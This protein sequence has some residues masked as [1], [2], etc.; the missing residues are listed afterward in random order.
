M[1]ADSVETV[2]EN[3]AAA[4]AID[5]N[6][7]SI[8]HTQWQAASPP[9]PHTFTVNLGVARTRGRFQV[10]ATRR[11]W[12][13]HH[14]PVALLHQRGRCELDQVAQGNFADAG[15]NASEKTVQFSTAPPPNRTPSLATISNQ[16]SVT[17]QADLAES[18]R[19][20]PGR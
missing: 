13:W 17:G 15:N 10:P 2:G 20:G 5:G 1:T 8:W 7:A 12:Q 9:P 19:F 16:N 18:Q 14:R 4:N 11:R 6:A 3:G